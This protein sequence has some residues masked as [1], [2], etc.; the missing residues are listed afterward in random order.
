MGSLA[1]IFGLLYQGREVADPAAW[2]RGAITVNVLV[3]ALAAA[4]ELLRLFGVPIAITSDQLTAIA[5]GVLALFNVVVLAASDRRV[6]LQGR[7][8]TPSAPEPSSN[9]PTQGVANA[10]RDVGNSIHDPGPG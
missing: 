2:K 5:G 8:Q 9:P 4:V 7:A 6:G 3:P 10:P 1:K